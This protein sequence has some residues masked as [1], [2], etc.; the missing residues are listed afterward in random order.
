MKEIHPKLE[1]LANEFVRERCNTFPY[2]GTFYGFA[3]YYPLLAYPSKERIEL[4]IKFLENLLQKTKDIRK[5]IS[6]ELDKIDLE[7]L[8][9][10]LKLEVF[11]LQVSSYE[12]S[13]V[14]PAYLTL[15]G[16]YNI[17]Q[18]PRLSDNEKLEFILARLNQ[19]KVLFES[20]RQTW[21]SATLLALEDSIPQAENLEKTLTIML[22]PLMDSFPQKKP[23][24]EDLITVISKKGKSFAQWLVNEVKPRTTSTC[25]VLGKENYK[26]LLEIRKESHTWSERLQIGENSLKRSMKRLKNLALR[27]VPEKGTVEA[28]LSK[29]KSNLPDIPILEESRNAHQKVSTF[30]KDKHLLQVPDASFEIA[31]PPSWD[32]FWG[33]GMLGFTYAEILSNEPLL[34]VIVV[35]PRTE[36]GKRELNRSSILLGIA[37]EGAAGHLSSYLLRKKR[38]NIIRLLIPP[39]TGID[40]RWTFYWEQLLRE[41]G[42]EP[43]IEYEFYQQYRVFWCS[44]RHICDVKLHC[45]LMSFEECVEFL[46]KEGRVPPIMAKAYVKAIAEMPGYFSSFITGKERLIKLREYTKEQLG[47]QYSPELFHKWVGEAGPI[48]YILLRREIKERVKQ[49]ETERR[50]RSRGIGEQ[51]ILKATKPKKTRFSRRNDNS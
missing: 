23:I 3:E 39:D 25:R 28:A 51:N 38:G 33:E 13:N 9:F 40:D 17:L 44:L 45:K 29:V 1:L 19:S 31:E 22:K 10:I 4:F 37:H 42:I 30:L 14:C 6:E 49:T 47:R 32:P 35:P 21:G 12:E 11:R 24:L 20:L 36:K 7:L 8:Q 43:T 34:K 5:D 27:L 18:L 16:V 46:E 48:P 50:A 15:N 26:R 2:L 41:E